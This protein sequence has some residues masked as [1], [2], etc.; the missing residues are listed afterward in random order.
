MPDDSRI[1]AAR[2]AALDRQF[3]KLRWYGKLFVIF[4]LLLVVAVPLRIVSIVVQKIKYAKST[5]KAGDG[6]H[7]P[8]IRNLCRRLP[9]H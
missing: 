6:L 4:Y 5:E 2:L 9:Q 8:Q 3:L 1:A 7:P